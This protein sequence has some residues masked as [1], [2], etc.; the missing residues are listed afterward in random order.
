[1]TDGHDDREDRDLRGAFAR[2]RA[3][4]RGR[5]PTYGAVV[6]GTARARPRRRLHALALAS[7]SAA[8]AAGLAVSWL[9][10]DRGREASVVT[11]PPLAPAVMSGVRWEAPTD[12]LLRTSG[13]DLMR[14]VPN[15]GGT[16]GWEMMHTDAPRTR[17]RPTPDTVRDQGR[18]S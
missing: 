10:L 14:T 13:G 12:F 11:A 4:E 6:A 7:L 16:D 9:V 15:I 18:T 5:A 17:R 3:E 8:A 2:L 1:M